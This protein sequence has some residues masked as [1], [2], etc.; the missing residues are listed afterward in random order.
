MLFL[1]VFSLFDSLLVIL[2]L[3]DPNV[4][5]QART[6]RILV[7]NVLKNERESFGVQQ[8]PLLNLLKSED[9]DWLVFLSLSEGGR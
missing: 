8:L 9:L 1:S 7:R 5:V 2:V 6:L 3:E 4:L